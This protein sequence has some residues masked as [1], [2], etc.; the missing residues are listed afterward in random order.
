[1]RV[2]V[3]GG[4]IAGMSIALYLKQLNFEVSVHERQRLAASGGHAFLMHH[5]GMSILRELTAAGLVLPGS[6][7]D[8]FDF[9]NAENELL[10]EQSLEGWH[11]FKRT[12]LLACLEKALEGSP[13]Y[14]EHHFSHFLYAGSKATAAVFSD[15]SVVEGDLFIGADGANSA[16]RTALFGAVH[17]EPGRVKEVV[18]LVKL[19]ELA[20][21][22]RATFTKYQDQTKGLSCGL[23][24]ASAQDVVWFMQYDPRLMDIPEEADVRS[25]LDYAGKLSS[26]CR[27]LL[28]DFPFHVQRVLAANDFSGSY[29]WNTRDLEVLPAFHVQNMVLIGDAAHVSLPFTSAGTTNALLDARVLRDQLSAGG[30][31]EAALKGYYEKRAP[32]IA[33]HVLLGRSLRDAFLAAESAPRLPLIEI[34][35]D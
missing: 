34:K 4:G 3:I 33:P 21:R 5:E 14:N 27:E 35:R 2:V 1:M 31:L 9:R 17:F 13:V 7:V 20:A 16:V 26:L 25:G 15:G 22:L 6:L 32:E 23:I 11:C 10:L 18:G 12:D 19:P 8:R 29:V 30:G 28:R 24:P